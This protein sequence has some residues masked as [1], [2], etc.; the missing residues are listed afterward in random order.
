MSDFAAGML[1]GLVLETLAIVLVAYAALRYA[2]ALM[3]KV[4]NSGGGT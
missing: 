3:R 4:V 1:C 2:K